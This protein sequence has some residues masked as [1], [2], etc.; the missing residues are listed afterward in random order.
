MD[1]E[2]LFNESINSEFTD[3]RLIDSESIE[4]EYIQTETKYYNYIAKDDM[5]LYLNDEITSFEHVYICPYYINT[6]AI[7]PFLNFIFVKSK[8]NDIIQF[9]EILFFKQFETIELINYSKMF[10]F[11]L[12]QKNDF[13][14]FISTINFDGFYNFEKKLYLFFD[15]TKCEIKINDVY[16]NSKIWVGI[17]DEIVNHKKICNFKIQEDVTDLFLYNDNFCFL[18]SNNNICYE[19]PVVNYIGTSKELLKFKYA[20]G[21]SVQNKNAMLGPYFYFT[22]YN[23]AFNYTIPGI[24]ETNMSDNDCIIRFAIF[25][26]NVKY[27]ENY[28]NDTIDESEIKKMRLEDPNL[29][30]NMERLT[31]RISDHD[32]LWSKE[33]NS[34]YVGIIELDNGEFLKNAPFIVVKEYEQQSPLS[35][36]YIDKKRKNDYAIL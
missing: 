10:L 2:F 21:E 36:H 26:G 27:I 33:Y 31:L 11:G 12:F 22:N 7:E 29:D 17:I 15:V 35:Y 14:K 34:A 6:K 5:S 25:S 1:K 3:S 9:P 32:G 20:F 18:E 16:S 4:N 28:L 24:Q 23:N 30:Q 19:I 8:I 13:E